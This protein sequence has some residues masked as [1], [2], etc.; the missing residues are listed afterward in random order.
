MDQISYG[1]LQFMM[2]DKRVKCDLFS[3]KIQDLFF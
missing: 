1:E 3:I 2:H